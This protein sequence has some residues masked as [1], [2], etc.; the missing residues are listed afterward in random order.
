[1]D[2]GQIIN[3]YDQLKAGVESGIIEKDQAVCIIYSNG[4]NA[5]LSV[6]PRWEISSPFFKTNPESHWTDY[7][8][9]VFIITGGNTKKTVLAVAKLWAETRYNVTGWAKNRAG[10]FVPKTLNEKLP[11]PERQKDEYVV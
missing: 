11:I 2:K 5:R 9:Q 8:R 10:D 7:G 1:M 6:Y 4:R 3:T